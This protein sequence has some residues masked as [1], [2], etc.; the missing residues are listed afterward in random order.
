M[1]F[2]N[3]FLYASQPTAEGSADALSPTRPNNLF[4]SQAQVKIGNF[5]F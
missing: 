3:E 2:Y 4:S 1:V 5:N